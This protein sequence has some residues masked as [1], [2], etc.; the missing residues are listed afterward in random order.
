M[1]ITNESLYE[2]LKGVERPEDLLGD[3]DE[4]IAKQSHNTRKVELPAT[5]EPPA[6]LYAILS[7]ASPTLRTFQPFTPVPRAYRS[8]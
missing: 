4:R 5:S 6:Q 8:S 7:S 3:A 1:T 2:P